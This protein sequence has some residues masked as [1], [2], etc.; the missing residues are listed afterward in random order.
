MREK[1]KRKVKDKIEIFRTQSSISTSRFSLKVVVLYYSCC[2]ARLAHP[3]PNTDWH[4]NDE[5]QMNDSWKLYFLCMR[6]VGDCSLRSH[7]RKFFDFD[8]MFSSCKYLVTKVMC[9]QRRSSCA[10]EINHFLADAIKME[11][12]IFMFLLDTKKNN[13]R[14]KKRR[15]HKGRRRSKS[16]DWLSEFQNQNPFIKIILLLSTEQMMCIEVL[17]ICLSTRQ[18]CVCVCVCRQATR[19]L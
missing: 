4:V 19:I 6:N 7:R 3:S 9:G 13:G 1:E 11:S 14:S 2:L 17:L 18:S 15:R 12:R 5:K 16:I 10:N 8:F